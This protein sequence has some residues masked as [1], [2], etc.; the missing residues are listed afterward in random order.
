MTPVRPTL[1]K[2]FSE[3]SSENITKE[4][5]TRAFGDENYEL[6]PQF[7]I[8]Y[9]YAT[10][11]KQIIE[12]YEKGFPDSYKNQALQCLNWI[13]QLRGDDRDKPDAYLVARALILKTIHLKWPQPDRLLFDVKLSVIENWADFFISYTRRNALETNNF[14]DEL[15]KYHFGL[16]SERDAD[17]EILKVENYV[18]RVL[19]KY[20][21]QHNIHG[22]VDFNKLQCGDDIADKIL[23]NC[24]ATIA[25]IQ[26]VESAT[27]QEPRLLAISSG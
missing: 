7:G 11:A 21:E 2:V 14:H 24:R 6:L 3:Y 12:R 9:N 4:L 18:A 5:L 10:R 20:L 8:E 26:L 23:T 1:L 25:F 16:S 19:A 15:I 22:F 13:I 17:Q 27:L